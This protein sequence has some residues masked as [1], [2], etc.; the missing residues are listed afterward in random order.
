MPEFEFPDPAG[1][2]RPVLA[3]VAL[4]LHQ[5]LA[6]ALPALVPSLAP[7]AARAWLRL[8]LQ[9]RLDSHAKS[10]REKAGLAAA[11]LVHMLLQVGRACSP[12]SAAAVC[13][14]FQPPSLT[15]PSKLVASATACSGGW[16]VP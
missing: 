14:A 12:L 8:A 9:P 4:L 7:D 15:W 3:T 2:P 13:F 10:Q 6:A 16:G 1:K 5:A 11:A